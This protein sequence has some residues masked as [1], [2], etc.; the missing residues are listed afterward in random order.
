MHDLRKRRL[1]VWSGVLDQGLELD[2]LL[3]LQ[4]EQVDEAVCAE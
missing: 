1:K 2:Q 4:E 3:R